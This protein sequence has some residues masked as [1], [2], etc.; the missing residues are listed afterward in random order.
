MRTLQSGERFEIVKNLYDERALSELLDSWGDDVRYRTLEN[1]WV[2]TY[3]VAG[4]K[5]RG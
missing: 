5:P 3:R 2:L 4:R 1:F